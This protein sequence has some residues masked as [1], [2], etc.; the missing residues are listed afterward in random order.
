MAKIEIT[1]DDEQMEA[2]SEGRGLEAL[3][4]PVLNEILEAEMTEHVGAEP[5]ERT[6]ERTGRRNGHYP[7]ELTTRVGTL[8]LRVPRDREGNFETDLFDRYQ[9]SEKALVLSMMEMVVNGVSTRKV[10][11]ITEKLCGREFSKSTVSELS[12]ELNE[13]V[14][15]WNERALDGQR[16]PFVLVDAMRIKVRRQRAVRSTSALIVVGINRRRLPRDPRR[17][18]RQLRVSTKLVGDVPLVETTWA[19]RRRVCHLRRP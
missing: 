10:R 8:E 6:D 11:N 5:H 18:H 19:S 1:I 4:K 3:L 13:Q 9:R 2:I 7:R 15:A 14:E 16:Y 17:S 12:K